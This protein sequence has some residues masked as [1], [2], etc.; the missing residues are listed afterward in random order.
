[1][2]FRALFP[3][4]SALALGLV[5]LFAGTTPAEAQFGKR[6]KDAVKRTAEEK[7]IQKATT[8]ES[9]AIDKATEGGTPGGEAAA[10]DSAA[11]AAS[12][13]ASSGAP[14]VKPGEGAW[15]NFDFKPG[16]RALFVDDFSKDEVGNF[17]A[18]LEL[19][20]GNAEVVEWQG[21]RFLSIPRPA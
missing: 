12:P 1:M 16:N 11:P 9:K 4:L 8:E 13:A 14:A 10:G 18:R 19:K 6:L 5:L 7:A 20:R 3:S 21:R 15:A 2:S 17:P